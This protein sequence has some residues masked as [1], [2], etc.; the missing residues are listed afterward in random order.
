MR[1]D[2]PSRRCAESGE[3]EAGSD[4]GSDDDGG[5]QRHRKQ[6][7]PVAA[8]RAQAQPRRQQVDQLEDQQAGEQGRQELQFEGDAECKRAKAPGDD[9]G[10]CH[11]RCGGSVHGTVRRQA[12]AASLGKGRHLIGF[13]EPAWVLGRQSQAQV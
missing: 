7:R 4:E 5:D 12:Q 1:I 9:I 6:A 11:G 13:P 3:A 2:R 10:T 8:E